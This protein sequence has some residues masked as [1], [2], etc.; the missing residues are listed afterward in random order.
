MSV[1]QQRI[2]MIGM[3]KDLDLE[4]P[5]KFDILIDDLDLIDFSPFQAVAEG[6]RKRSFNDL[7]KDIFQDQNVKKHRLKLPKPLH[8]FLT[9]YQNIYIRYKQKTTGIE[10]GWKKAI[11]ALAVE[12]M[13]FGL[14]SMYAELLKMSQ[15]LFNFEKS[16][17]NEG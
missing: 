9:V 13:I 7:S 4:D 6:V 11:P 14:P 2:N 1:K 16:E 17:N 8:D 12:T 10:T 15:F 3:I 5:E